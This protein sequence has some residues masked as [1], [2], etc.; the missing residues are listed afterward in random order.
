MWPQTILIQTRPWSSAEAEF[1]CWTNRVG[2]ISPDRHAMMNAT[3]SACA[4]EGD[5]QRQGVGADRPDRHQQRL[6]AAPLGCTAE[7]ELGVQ[8]GEARHRL[9]PLRAGTGYRPGRGSSGTEGDG[10]P[11]CQCLTHWPVKNSRPRSTNCPSR[12]AISTDEI[13]PVD[14]WTLS[15]VPITWPDSIST[16]E[17]GALIQ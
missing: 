3:R 5:G 1:T 16:T 4:T 17:T 2:E 8:V 10:S 15:Q 11:T 12:R 13:S 9:A 6:D 14:G 7:G